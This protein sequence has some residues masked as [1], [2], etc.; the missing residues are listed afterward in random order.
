MAFA[1]A[2]HGLS[3]EP[4]QSDR[5]ELSSQGRYA[6]SEE[7]GACLCHKADSD[8]L[9]KVDA[10]LHCFFWEILGRMHPMQKRNVASVLKLS[11]IHI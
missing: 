9:P 1:L 4:L 3:G 5:V 11:L 2:R 10:F 8:Q 7:P 6:A